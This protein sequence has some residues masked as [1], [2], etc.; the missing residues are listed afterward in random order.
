MTE[1]RV[2]MEA[3]LDEDLQKEAYQPL[4]LNF[5]RDDMVQWTT[6]MGELDATLRRQRENTRAMIA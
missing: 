1:I 2:V 3:N 6:R 4:I 5:P